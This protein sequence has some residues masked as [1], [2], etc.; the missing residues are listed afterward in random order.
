MLRVGARKSAMIIPVQDQTK[1]DK[2]FEQSLDQSRVRLQRQN[3]EAQR[4]APSRQVDE[5]IDADFVEVAS[6]R[7][8]SAYDGGGALKKYR[9]MT[10]YN[11]QKVFQNDFAKY[12]SESGPYTQDAFEARKKILLGRC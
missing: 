10:D 9:S 2:A 12:Q 7:D 6:G 3:F 4:V 5:V 1:T 11:R 8:V